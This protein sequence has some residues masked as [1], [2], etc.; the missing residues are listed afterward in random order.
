MLNPILRIFWILILM[1]VAVAPGWA[2]RGWGAGRSGPGHGVE[3]CIALL[4]SIPKQAL[5]ST[6]AAGLAYIREEEKL[7]HDV[8]V[9]LQTKWG[10]RVFGN[11]LQSKDS[12]SSAIRILLDRYGL[13]DPAANRP[14][15]QR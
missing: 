12:H 11:I 8:F 6:E 4:H 14:G 15:R 10:A 9:A 1:T 5:D 13:P 7:A 2:Q 3:N